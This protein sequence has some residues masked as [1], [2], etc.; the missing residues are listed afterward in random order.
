VGLANLGSK[1]ESC[2]GSRVRLV[3]AT[4]SFENNFYRLPSTP[5]L[6]GSPYRSFS[7]AAENHVY[8]VV[9]TWVHSLHVVVVV[10]VTLPSWVDPPPLA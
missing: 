4:I 1:L 6:S 9:F 7:L 2:V 5:P 8:R 10:G 3:G